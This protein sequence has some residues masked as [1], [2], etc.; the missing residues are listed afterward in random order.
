[1]VM[2]NM[3]TSIDKNHAIF[4]S[5]EYLK[6]IVPFSLMELI[7]QYPMLLESNEKDFII[8]MTAPHMPIWVWTSELISETSTTQLCE[9]FFNQF[10]NGQSVYYVAKPNIASIL[11]KPFIEKL[12]ATVHRIGME[13]FENPKV[14]SPKNKSVFIERPT[15]IDVDDI[16]ICMANFEKECFNRVVTPNSL[17]EKAKNKLENP[18]FFVIKQNNSVVA[19]A[20]SSR[21][22]DTHIAINQVY[23]MPEYRGQGFAAALVAYISN[24]IIQTGKT[25]AL[26]TDLSNPSSNKA[27][28]NV[29]F[30]E[31]GKVDEITLTWN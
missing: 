25:P 18:Y 24:L 17:I 3:I 23:T 16:A 2:I 10:R 19:T 4:S 29:G 28:K 15:D 7:K 20:Q 9:Y 6:D 11:S 14:I 22:T 12:N 21:E 27:Y 13:S 30:I 1:M 26:Y 5:D 31:K 8:G